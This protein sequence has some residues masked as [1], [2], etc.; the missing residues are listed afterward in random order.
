MRPF[1]LTSANSTQLSHY[2]FKEEFGP[3]LEGQTIGFHYKP[4]SDSYNFVPLEISTPGAI[5]S[6]PKLGPIVISEIMYHGTVEYLELLNVSSKPIPLRDW[7]IEQ[8]IEIQISSDLVI[9]PE[10]TH[11]PLRKCRPLPISLP[12]RKRACDSRMGRRKTQ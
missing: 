4:S 2:H 12:T 3:S 5:N 11:Y 6:L 1:Y 8:G 9:K 10:P 7:K